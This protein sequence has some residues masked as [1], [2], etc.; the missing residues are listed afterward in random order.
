MRRI[1]ALAVTT[2][3]A[4]SLASPAVAATTTTF[5]WGFSMPST[6]S[7]K[8]GDTVKFTWSGGLPHNVVGPNFRSGNAKVSGT[9]SR[10]FS[11]KG[12]FS[13]YCQP[14]SSIMKVT[15]VVS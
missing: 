5:A 9:Y 15:V 2:A 6:I 4:A 1:A 14:H 10:K 8:K 3:A 7:I 11:S 13:V 12:S